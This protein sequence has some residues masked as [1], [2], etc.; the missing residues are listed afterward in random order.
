MPRSQSVRFRVELEDAEVR[1]V[2]DHSTQ[3]TAD[4]A[5]AHIEDFDL[6]AQPLNLPQ[7]PVQPVPNSR[8]DA[9]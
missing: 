4:L 6:S 2:A 8:N 3:L 5:A 1:E 7:P 9:H